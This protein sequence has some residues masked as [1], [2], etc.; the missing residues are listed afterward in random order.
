MI[1]SFDGEGVAGTLRGAMAFLVV[2]SILSV[3][4]ALAYERHWEEFW[5]LMPWAALVLSGL[6]LVALMLRTSR[7][8]IR[9]ARIVAVLVLVAALLGIW[10]HFD[11]NYVTAVMD[12]D[13]A[14]RWGEMPVVE[15]VWTVANG[16]VGHV[17]VPAAGAL[18]PVGVTLWMTTLGLG[19]QSRRNPEARRGKP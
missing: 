16:S 17:P 1:R 4:V 7:A 13:Y 12:Q 10:R 5:Q 15:R 9:I 6:A 11:H 2:I 19:E 8:T 18:V 14:D 3:A